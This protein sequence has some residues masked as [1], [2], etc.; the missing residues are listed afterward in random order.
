MDVKTN[1]YVVELTDKSVTPM[2]NV[3]KCLLESVHTM[4]AATVTSAV[5]EPRAGTLQE[6]SGK[7]VGV[8][9]CAVLRRWPCT[10]VTDWRLTQVD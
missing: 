3:A 7:Y 10:V 4:E 6:I 8:G 5:A 1:L 9:G 2:I